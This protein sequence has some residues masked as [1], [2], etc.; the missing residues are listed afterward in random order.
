[1]N[2]DAA[3]L[4]IREGL[5]FFTGTSRD[6]AIVAALQA[7]QREL[8]KGKSLPKFLL[9]EDQTLTLLSGASTV[10]LPTGFIRT[11]EDEKPHFLPEDSTINLF[12]LRRLYIDANLAYGRFE[13]GAVTVTSGSPKVYVIRK[14]VIDFIQPADQN[15]SITW[16]YFKKAD[17]LTTNIENAW[18]A[19]E[20]DWL[21][22]EA[23]VRV[24][25]AMR[26]TDA[27]SLFTDMRDRARASWLAELV[28][29]E[30]ADGP[31]Q[32]GAN[33]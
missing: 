19:N 18:L 10:A 4:R 11:F 26:D 23:G 25:A 2:R 9:L 27:V 22:G 6:D 14:S 30:E 29:G 32:M 33:N 16:S 5:G 17:L 7:G 8:E 15:Y 12:L 24:A 28:V 31:Y 3:V 1:M 21:I 20:P 13:S